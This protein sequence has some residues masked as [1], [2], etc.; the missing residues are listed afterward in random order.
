M[1][2][3]GT[4]AGGCQTGDVRDP[5]EDEKQPSASVGDVFF[6]FLRTGKRTDTFLDVIL[7]STTNKSSLSL[8]VVGAFSSSKSETGSIGTFVVP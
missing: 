4:S 1:L 3:I 8:R 2:Q 5:W 7:L 6:V